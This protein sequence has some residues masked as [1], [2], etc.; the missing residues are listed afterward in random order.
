MALV[1]DQSLLIYKLRLGLLNTRESVAQRIVTLPRR[2]ENEYVAAMMPRMTT[3]HTTHDDTSGSSFRLFR[4]PVISRR[5]QPQMPLGVPM[6]LQLAGVASGSGHS[7]GG[8]G[9]SSGLAATSQADLHRRLPDVMSGSSVVLPGG[10]P[11]AN[12]VSMTA[13]GQGVVTTGRM[14]FDRSMQRMH[15]TGTP[16]GNSALLSAQRDLAKLI[17]S[18]G[19]PQ[20]HTPPPVDDHRLLPSNIPNTC[21]IHPIV[22]SIVP[23]TPLP[24]ATMVE[25]LKPH[26]TTPVESVMT[27]TVKPT[28]HTG[29]PISLHS[30]GDKHPHRD[31]LST[32]RIPVPLPAH[33]LINYHTPVADRRIDHV[34]R[35]NLVYPRSSSVPPEHKETFTPTTVV[36]R[37]ATTTTAVPLSGPVESHPLVIE[38]RQHQRSNSEPGNVPPERLCSKRRSFRV[39][40]PEESATNSRNFTAAGNGNG[41]G[42]GDGGDDGRSVSIGSPSQYSIPTESRESVSDQQLP[43]ILT[44][45]AGGRMSP[46]TDSIEF[47]EQGIDL[48]AVKSVAIVNRAS[49]SVLNSFKSLKPID[50]SCTAQDAVVGSLSRSVKIASGEHPHG[51][52]VLTANAIATTDKV[53]SLKNNQSIDEVVKPAVDQVKSLEHVYEIQTDESAL[54]TH[55]N[56]F[57]KRL[58]SPS[59]G[60]PIVSKTLESLGSTGVSQQP[61]SV[62]DPKHISA[63]SAMMDRKPSRINPFAQTYAIFSGKS[64]SNPMSLLI[65][66]PF[67]QEPFKPLCISVKPDASVEE[68]I[69]FTLFEYF[70][71]ARLP[72]LPESAWFIT[73]WSLRIVEDDGTI[74]D[75][76]PALDRSRK[77]QKFAF[78]RFALYEITPIEAPPARTL[79]RGTPQPSSPKIEESGH[80]LGTDVPTGTTG[81]S[82]ASVFLKVHLY[83]TLEIKQTTTMQM[84]LNIPMSEVFN[85]I[86]LKRKYDPKDYVLKMADTKTDVPLEKTLAQLDAIEFCVL[87]RSSGGAGDIFLRPPDEPIGEDADDKLFLTTEDLRSVYKQYYVIYKH[88][89]GRHERNLTID[90]EYIHLVASEGKALFDMGKTTNSFHVSAVVSCKQ[91]KKKSANFKLVVRR[92]HDSKV[93]DLEASNDTDARDICARVTAMHALIQISNGTENT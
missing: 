39:E 55:Q 54:K 90:G 23:Q 68:V 72:Q 84:P 32:E 45:G 77:I 88:L 10:R 49:I 67:S 8:L 28:A 71:V 66:L 3:G 47:E 62:L 34:N 35:T 16:D 85:R 2:D 40:I 6:H 25:P 27:T 37:A 69:G 41:N 46:D 36:P 56:M 58:L 19:P 74:D 21:T 57:S 78:D 92:N 43:M 5:E 38:R 18:L 75:D 12:P 22:A 13:L 86:C 73:N 51:D 81:A 61:S 26:F 80:S 24:V 82:S 29:V 7:P 50:H 20:Q 48:D 63:L 44:D 60:G 4:P 42:D 30:S 9:S 1:Q 31:V 70:D 53:E 64:I 76:F 59:Y 65:F 89:M 52:V 91:V 14:M 15:A 11:S 33:P 93:Y 83:S 17:K 87:K 79:P